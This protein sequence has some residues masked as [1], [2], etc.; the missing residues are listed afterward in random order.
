MNDLQTCFKCLPCEVSHKPTLGKLASTSTHVRHT[1]R[2]MY[3][4]IYMHVMT[5][6]ATVYDY[7]DIIL[8][9]AIMHLLF[10]Q[11]SQIT[12]FIGSLPAIRRYNGILYKYVGNHS[13]NISF[14]FIFL[15]VW[16]IHIPMW[17]IT[18]VSE[19]G[20]L[21]NGNKLCLHFLRS[22]KNFRLDFFVD[23]GG[24]QFLDFRLLGAI[25]HPLLLADVFSERRI[26]VGDFH[27]HRPLIPS[28][29]ATC[30]ASSRTRPMLRRHS[31]PGTRS[32][33]RWGST[34]G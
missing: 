5:Y 34:D 20:G 33:N 23:N 32:T 6:T 26:F 22:D 30:W 9:F 8:N 11:D 18:K 13:C 4:Y 16:V 7:I 27:Y 24:G 25:F 12:K 1:H 2:D 17:G 31:I 10:V 15:Y 3:I 28:A 21:R 19:I 29:T 14:S